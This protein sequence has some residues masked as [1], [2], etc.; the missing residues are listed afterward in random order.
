MIRRP[1]RSTLFPY[2]TLFRSLEEGRQH[3]VVQLTCKSEPLIS[4]FLPDRFS[5]SAQRLVL[6]G[7]PLACLMKPFGSNE[8]SSR[9]RKRNEA[10]EEAPS[11]GSQVDRS[12]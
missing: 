6:P 5:G 7:H 2:T 9:Q 8:P 1:P 11:T 12:N 3:L 10:K 4:S